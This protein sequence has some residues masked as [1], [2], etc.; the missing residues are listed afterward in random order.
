MESSG[1]P[2]A[3]TR[4]LFSMMRSTCPATGE[5]TLLGG[6]SFKGDAEL[7][8]LAAARVGS[9]RER[10]Q[11]GKS[12]GVWGTESPE[13]FPDQTKTKTGGK[14]ALAFSSNRRFTLNQYKRIH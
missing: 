5:R 14:S 11:S 12:Q 1:A 7:T 6:L 8:N 2:C 13:S 4:S 3:T 10:Q 9:K